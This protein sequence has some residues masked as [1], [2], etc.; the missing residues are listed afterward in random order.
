MDQRESPTF[1][2][3]RRYM[4]FLFGKVKVKRPFAAHA[5]IL[6]RLS[7][8]HLTREC[9]PKCWR[10]LSCYLQFFFTHGHLHCVRSRCGGDTDLVLEPA[11]SPNFDPEQQKAL[12]LR[13]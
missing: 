3:R 1:L 4:H 13:S 11:L 10:R 12:E 9:R 2:R 7:V 8:G 5:T 6:F